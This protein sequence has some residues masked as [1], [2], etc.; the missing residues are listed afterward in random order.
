M[1]WL[2]A[3]RAIGPTGC[4]R[5]GTRAHR[6]LVLTVLLGYGAVMFV[7]GTRD[8]GLLCH[9]Q[10]HAPGPLKR[11]RRQYWRT[12]LS[13]VCAN[14]PKRARY[15]HRRA[16]LT[17]VESMEAVDVTEW[18][19]EETEPCVRLGVTRCFIYDEARLAQH[20]DN[21]VRRVREAEGSRPVHPA[22]CRVCR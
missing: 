18:S 10:D 3:M 17:A 4:E 2:G 19:T 9:H 1:R 7:G 22:A 6:V 12:R 14:R 8:D 16:V 5:S 11:L 21:G 13:T 20:D 15:S